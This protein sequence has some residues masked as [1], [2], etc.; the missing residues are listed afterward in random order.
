MATNEVVVDATGAIA[1]LDRVLRRQPPAPIDEHAHLL[2]DLI[3]E[4]CD[5]NSDWLTWRPCRVCGR[6]WATTMVEG[7]VA[8]PRHSAPGSV[9]AFLR[10]EM[11]AYGGMI[12]HSGRLERL[13]ALAAAPAEPIL[14]VFA[15]R[16][17][18][19]GIAPDDAPAFDLAEPPRESSVVSRESSVDAGNAEY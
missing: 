17:R 8:C 19:N 10:A 5:L 2:R 12:D 16:A 6:R 11:A 9:A 7:V 14:P 18:L 1:E 15:E 3:W 13:A 4:A